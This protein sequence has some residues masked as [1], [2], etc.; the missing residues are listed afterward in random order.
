M[1]RKR[2]RT[3]EHTVSGDGHPP[4]T[5]IDGNYVQPTSRYL[6]RDHLLYPL[7]IVD[8]SHGL[9]GRGERVDQL[10]ALKVPPR[11]VA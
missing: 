4:F 9:G 7:A 8:P 6:M 10:S 3:R 1:S 2:Y 5:T 11:D